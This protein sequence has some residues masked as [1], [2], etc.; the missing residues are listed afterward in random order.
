[1]P[2]FMLNKDTW[3]SRW[4]ALEQSIDHTLA[5]M[6]EGRTPRQA[7]L[8][9]A[10]TALKTFGGRQF[11]FFLDGFDENKLTRLERSEEYPPEFALRTTLDQVA[12]DMEVIVR[13]WQQRMPSMASP[14]LSCTSCAV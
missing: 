12:Y 5:E 6:K 8:K 3:R 1:M 7:T 14:P 2:N 4:S 13:A 11:R 10:L 9:S